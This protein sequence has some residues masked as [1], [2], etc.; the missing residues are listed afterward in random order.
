MELRNTR[1]PVGPSMYSEVSKFF[2]EKFGEMA[3]WSNA[4]VSK[5][6][7]PGDWYLGFKSLSLRFFCFTMGALKQF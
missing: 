3:E 4:A 7:I 2:G 1:R 6:V 5:A